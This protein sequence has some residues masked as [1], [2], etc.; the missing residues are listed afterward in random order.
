MRIS[1]FIYNATTK[2]L[3][4]FKNVYK[5]INNYQVTFNKIVNLLIKIFYYIR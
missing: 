4:D 2:K 3:L 5:Y 1:Y